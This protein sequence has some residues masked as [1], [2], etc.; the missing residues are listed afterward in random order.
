[1]VQREQKIKFSVK[2]RGGNRPGRSSGA[3]D[4]AYLK[5]D[6]FIK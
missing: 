6:S 4:P 2:C 5:L 1:M 3:Y